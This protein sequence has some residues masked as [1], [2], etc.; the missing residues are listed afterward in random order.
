MSKKRLRLSC[1]RVSHTVSLLTI[2]LLAKS[3]AEQQITTV[4][5]TGVRGYS[6]DGGPG[7][8]AQINDPFGVI[9]GPEG[10]IYFCDTKNHV[11]RRVSRKDGSID[12]VVGSGEKGYSGDGEGPLSIA[13]NEP[14]EIRFHRNGDLYWVEMMNHVVRR[15]DARTNLVSTIAGTGIAGFSG[16][17]GPAKNAELNRPHSIQ[18]NAE[19]TE[20]LICDIKNHRLR[21]VDLA[22]GIISTW[23]GNGQR[24]PTEDGA[25]VSPET[26]LNGPRALDLSPTGDLW[27][28]LREGNQAFRINRDTSRLEHIAGTGK[29]GFHVESRPALESELS[30]PKGLAFSPDGQAVYLADTESHTV[31]AIRLDR[32]MPTL[33]LIA[34]TGRKGDGPGE[35]SPLD[36]AMA[37]LHGVGTDPV[38][39]DLYIGDS[40]AHRV[41]R[42]TGLPRQAARRSL[43]DYSTSEFEIAGAKGRVVVPER[44]APGNPWIWRCRF[45]GAFP[46]VD[47][48]LLEKGWHVV[49]VDVA[50]LFGG[51]EAMSRFDATYQMVTRKFEL[52][53]RVVL[54]GFSRGGLPAINWALLHPERVAGIYLDAPVL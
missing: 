30:G 1:L 52:S 39:G 50:N 37:R 29:K 12:T 44:A 28:A 25:I 27:L 15:L 40:E 10:D 46:S 42:V 2:W 54:E 24:Q 4:A 35:G 5:G 38:S 11:I 36:C 23:C 13:M 17:G 16:D 32:E 53:D 41:R 8:A 9:V 21:K 14:Y 49:S 22:S 26:P 6:G 3:P 33:E 7:I 18:F 20:L 19:G 48:A 47:E 34:G 51:P 43:G 45:F 31:R